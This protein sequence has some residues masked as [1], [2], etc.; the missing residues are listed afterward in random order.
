MNRSARH[1]RQCA[2]AMQELLTKY[3]VV[4]EDFSRVTF[5][6]RAVQVYAEHMLPHRLSRP[7]L[8]TPPKRQGPNFDTLKQTLGPQA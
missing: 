1:R 3:K 4:S 8:W 7:E 6:S 2:V 5:H